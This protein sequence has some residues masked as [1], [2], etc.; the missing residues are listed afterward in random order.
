MQRDVR[1]CF[2][3][4]EFLMYHMHDVGLTQQN[5]LDLCRAMHMT[6]TREL[7]N[8]SGIAYLEALENLTYEQMQKL[9][10]LVRE[11]RADPAYAEEYVRHA[12][13]TPSMRRRSVPRPG[14]IESHCDLFTCCRTVVQATRRLL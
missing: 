8:L 12:P 3:L 11:V 5:A 7:K 14:K 13:P 2:D 4:V 10:Q 9:L 6:D 1:V